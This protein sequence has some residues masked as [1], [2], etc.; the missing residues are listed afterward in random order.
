M[1]QLALAVEL[2]P[3]ADFSAY[4]PG[5]NAEAVAAVAGWALG[6]GEPFVFVSGPSGSGKTHLLQAA[7]RAA[8]DLDAVAVYLPLSHPG[9][10]PS[11]VEDL[12]KADLVA[13]DDFQAASGNRDWEAALFRLYNGLRDANRRLLIGADAPV[14]Q[15]GIALPDL[16][17]RLSWGPSY[18]LRPL[19]EDDCR[20][21][22][23]DSA[24]RRGLH[25][26]EES[27]SYI[28]SR[29]PRD[30]GSLLN[31]LDTLDRESLRNKRRLTVSLIR[32]SLS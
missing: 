19:D 2:R 16:R 20:R 12:E 18:R 13:L 21:L 30:P 23:I 1:Q 10:D 29:C 22:L 17:S 27:A 4:L 3:E 32:A 6:N 26:S 5:P 31:L 11:A 25:L 15:L 9:L 28:L 24:A 8:K 14:A 7:C